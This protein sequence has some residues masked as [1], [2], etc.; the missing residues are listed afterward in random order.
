MVLGPCLKSL[1]A[2]GLS[3]FWGTCVSRLLL[4]SVLGKSPLQGASAACSGSGVPCCRDQ[5][6]SQEMQRVHSSK[7]G[8][9]LRKRE[10]LKAVQL[11]LASTFV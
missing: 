4:L 10:E 3:C 9:L 8:F 5:K 7:P 6:P 11:L 1:H 2:V